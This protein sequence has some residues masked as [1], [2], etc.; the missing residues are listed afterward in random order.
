M[1]CSSFTFS[2]LIA[3]LIAKLLCPS[4][5]LP[6]SQVIY[7]HP[8]LVVEFV[9]FDGILSSEPGSSATPVP[10]AN[11]CHRTIGS[12]RNAVGSCSSRNEGS[13]MAS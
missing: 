7:V 6:R 12:T 1:H 3:S 4:C 10:A 11:E 2:R 5:Q 8:N 13:C 9:M